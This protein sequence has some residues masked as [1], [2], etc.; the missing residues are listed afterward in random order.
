MDN[1]IVKSINGKTEISILPFKMFV[2]FDEENLEIA[3]EGSKN[4]TIALKGNTQFLFDGNAHFMSTGEF[5]IITDEENIYFE[6]M[7]GRV[8]FNSRLAEPIK[9]LPESIQKRKEYGKEQNKNKKEVE[10]IHKEKEITEKNFNLHIE[11]LE[12][13]I[14]KLENKCRQLDSH[15]EEY[16]NKKYAEGL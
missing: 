7:K 5:G 16:S 13:R 1:V 10:R 15:L 11:S 9:G 3:F 4:N 8:H 2:R 12:N 6:S 14:L